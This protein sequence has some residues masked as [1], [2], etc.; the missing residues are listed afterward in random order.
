LDPFLFAFGDTAL[1][2]FFSTFSDAAL[3]QFLSNFSDTALDPFVSVFG[4]TALDPF[5]SDF[6]ETALDPFVS[7][8]DD[9]A[10]DQFRGNYLW[11]KLFESSVNGTSEYLRENTSTYAVYSFRVSA[12]KRFSAIPQFLRQLLQRGPRGY[13]SRAATATKKLKESWISVHQ[14]TT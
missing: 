7:A 6:G 8:F 9:T 12:L 3:D 14:G 11:G 2:L 1:D 13:G 10:V 4:D 5:L